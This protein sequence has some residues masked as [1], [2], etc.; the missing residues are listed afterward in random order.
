MLCVSV[1]LDAILFELELVKAVS[2]VEFS[3]CFVDADE[4][5][6]KLHN[7]HLK[8]IIIITHTCVPYLYVIF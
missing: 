3:L 4:K 8:S 1:R 2:Y 7:L 5:N 6:E